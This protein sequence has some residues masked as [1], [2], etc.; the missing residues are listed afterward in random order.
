MLLSYHR[1]KVQQLAFVLSSSFQCIN[2]SRHWF[3]IEKRTDLRISICMQLN[4]Q[5]QCDVLLWFLKA[6]L[7][8]SCLSW[9]DHKIFMALSEEGFPRTVPSSTDIMKW[10]I[11]FCLTV[12]SPGMKNAFILPLPLKLLPVT[13]VLDIL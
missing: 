11:N 9:L 8:F 6:S 13:W 3:I 10:A 4:I 2:R 7:Y 1:C 5:I 12:W